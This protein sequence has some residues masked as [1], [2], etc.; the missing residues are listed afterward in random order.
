MV[1]LLVWLAFRSLRI[2]LMSVVPNLLPA[3]ACFL[4]LRAFDMGLRIDSALVLCISIGGLFNTTIHF[5]ARVRQRLG[6][7]VKR[8]TR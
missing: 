4:A 3:I 1:V 6:K 7:P 5:A 2:A 8:P